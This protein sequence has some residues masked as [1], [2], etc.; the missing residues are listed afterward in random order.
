M[1]T[2]PTTIKKALLSVSDKRGIVEF[3]SKLVA[4]DVEIISTGGTA[5]IL[6]ESG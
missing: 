5:K 3:A 4:A 6:Q 1:N 2:Q